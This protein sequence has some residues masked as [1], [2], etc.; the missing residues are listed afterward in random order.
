MYYNEN[1]S[2]CILS[3]DGITLNCKVETML[4]EAVVD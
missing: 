2:T 1:L 3:K 4:R